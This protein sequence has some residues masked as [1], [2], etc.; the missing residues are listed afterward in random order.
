[1]NLSETPHPSEPQGNPSSSKTHSSE[2]QRNSSFKWI[3]GKPSFKWTSAKFLTQMNHNEAPHSNEP[4]PGPSLKWTTTKPL[5]Q[6]NFNEAPHSN[7]PQRSPSLKWTT[8]KTLV[9]QTYRDAC[10]A[11]SLKMS[12][13]L[14]GTQPGYLAMVLHDMAARTRSIYSSSSKRMLHR[15][16]SEGSQT[17]QPIRSQLPASYI[18]SGGG[19]GGGWC[20]RCGEGEG[21]E[22][23]SLPL[24]WLVLAKHRRKSH[25]YVG[26]FK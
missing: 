18:H 19:E 1:M 11:F 6:M 13:P 26:Q 23:W 9:Q 3:T 10:R 7:E 12:S 25:I 5:T 14:T 15:W 24:A 21:H 4:Q 17:P 22:L 8:T 2:P 16:R 20:W